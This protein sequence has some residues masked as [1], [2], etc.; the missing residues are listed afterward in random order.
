[1]RGAITLAL[2][3]PAC[4][5]VEPS[6]V[7]LPD[8][9]VQNACLYTWPTVLAAWKERLSLNPACEHVDADISIEITDPTDLL[10][11]KADGCTIGNTM[12]VRSTLT[13]D[14][15]ISV[16]THEWIHVLRMCDSGVGDADQDHTDTRLWAATDS[17]GVRGNTVEA[18]AVRN[19]PHG[20]CLEGM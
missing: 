8:S 17:A 9:P 4:S 12:F 13:D 1:M 11:P 19:K 15:K 7:W 2:L 14:Q 20:H 5:H 16:V 6:K 3:L 10:C 18:I